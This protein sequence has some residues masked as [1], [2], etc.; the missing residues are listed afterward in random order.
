MISLHMDMGAL[1]NRDPMM[2]WIPTKRLYKSNGQEGENPITT[3]LSGSQETD[4][5]W[6]ASTDIS[7]GFNWDSTQKIFCH[8]LEETNKYKRASHFNTA[9]GWLPWDSITLTI[10][11]IQTAI[12]QKNGIKQWKKE[13]NKEPGGMPGPTLN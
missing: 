10:Y 1:R 7:T 3:L 2:G 4:G 9:C 11:M 12:K 13:I 8:K 6:T 5:N